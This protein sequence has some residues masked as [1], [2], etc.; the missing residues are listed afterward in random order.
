[1]KIT[2]DMHDE[3][4]DFINSTTTEQHL[5]FLK[6]VADRI[7]INLHKSDRCRCY[8]IDE[9]F[10]QMNLNGMMIDINIFKINEL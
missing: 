7:S 1:M 8:N 10:S 2:P 5:F 3:V 9:P 6:C 4:I